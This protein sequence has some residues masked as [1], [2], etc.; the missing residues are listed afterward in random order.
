MQMSRTA[1]TLELSSTRPAEIPQKNSHAFA[2]ST[3]LRGFIT[4]LSAHGLLRRVSEPVD[5]K[6]ELGERTRNSQVPLLFENVRGYPGHRVFT[7]G[8]GNFS[9]I[10]LALGMLP[11]QSRPKAIEEIKKRISAARPPLLLES[12]PVQK[13][14]V[15]ADEIDFLKFPVPHWSREESGRYIGTWHINVTRDPESRA[16]NVGVYR[17]QVLGR[18][19]ATV[20]TSARSH[21]ARHFAKSEKQGRPLEMAVAIGVPE[22]V[23]IAAGASCPFGSDEY[24]LAGSLSGDPVPLLKCETVDLEVPA[25]S[26]IVIEGFLH[27]HKRVPDGPYFDYTGTPNT[28]PSAYLF[29]ATRLMFRDNPIFRGAAIGYAGAEDLQLFALLAELGLLDFHGSRL[30]HAVQKVLMQLRWFRTFQLAGRI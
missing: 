19:L 18:N 30:R 15:E 17:M 20:S 13:N 24:E 21:L 1:A 28:N 16:R 2:S 10:A 12:G 14:I 5:W 9:A 29:E 6:F 27:P 23:M 22:P 26:E 8:L 11:K 25:N 7:N 4:S 3:D